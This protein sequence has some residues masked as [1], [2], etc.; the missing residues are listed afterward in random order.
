VD[1]WTFIWL[2]FLLKIPIAALLG[3]V[4]WAIHQDPAADLPDDDGG[5]SKHLP[6][7]PRHPHRPYR[8]RRPRRG[9][10]GGEFVRPPARVRTTHASGRRFTRS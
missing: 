9:P 5:G 10:H 6:P 3:I 7:K 8:P 1:V 2:M 4:W